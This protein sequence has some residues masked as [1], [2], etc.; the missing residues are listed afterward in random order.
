MT[1]ELLSLFHYSFLTVTYS[2]YTTNLSQKMMV[3]ISGYGNGNQILNVKL[4]LVKRLS[5]CPAY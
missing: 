4:V 2:N 1:E 3:K 5:Y